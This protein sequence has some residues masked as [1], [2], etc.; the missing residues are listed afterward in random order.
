[1]TYIALN[2]LTSFAECDLPVCT[3]RKLF[4]WSKGKAEIVKNLFEV[5]RFSLLEVFNTRLDSLILFP[6]RLK[7]TPALT[8]AVEKT[9][10]YKIFN[11]VP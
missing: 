8:L 3:C 4:D 7:V 10:E 9:A 11:L 2:R 1:M 6:P 5:T